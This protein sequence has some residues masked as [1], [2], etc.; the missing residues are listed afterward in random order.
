MRLKVVSLICGLMAA[1]AFGEDV[2]RLHSLIVAAAT[3][4]CAAYLETRTAILASGSSALPMLAHYAIEP[5]LTWQQRLVVRV[6]YERL[7]RGAEI[8]ALRSY[9]WRTDPGYD[10]NWERNIVG[11]GL[12]LEMIAVPKIREVGLWYYYV[13]L[14]WKETEETCNSKFDDVRRRWPH[15]CLKAVSTLPEHYWYQLAV[16]ERMSATP[17]SAWH[18]GRYETFLREKNP[19]TVPALV[20]FYDAFNKFH[21]VGPEQYEG[22]N[23]AIYRNEFL[24][25]LSFADS[26]HA[27]LLEKFIAE[28]TA[29]TPLKARLAEVR[30]RPAPPLQPEPPFRL[31]TNVVVIAQ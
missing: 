23:A 24:P 7:I 9:D 8:E 5:S 10:K 30:A 22:E 6:C 20:N 3:N 31:G 26:R 16:E 11:P 14:T 1:A 29:L 21:V 25:V 4:R 18:Q 12:K 28:K 2:N 27:D 19:D 15:W 17:F 13:E